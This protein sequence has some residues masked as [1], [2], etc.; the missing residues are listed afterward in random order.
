MVLYTIEACDTINK[1]VCLISEQVA[2]LQLIMSV[3]MMQPLLSHLPAEHILL[4]GSCSSLQP[5][6]LDFAVEAP[7][8]L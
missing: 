8:G 5:A 1:Q 4:T 7:V 2:H 3:I 6:C